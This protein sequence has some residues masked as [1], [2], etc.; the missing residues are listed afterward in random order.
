[1]RRCCD[2]VRCRGC[3]CGRALAGLAIAAMIV[4]SAPGATTEH[5]AIS[6]T[7]SNFL[8][9]PPHEEVAPASAVS[10]RVVPLEL[11]GQPPS[12]FGD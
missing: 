7:V 12:A 4:T 11:A 8:A 3:L 5:M 2:D 1:M 9:V 10:V 6:A